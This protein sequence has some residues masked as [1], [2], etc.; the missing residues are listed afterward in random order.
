MIYT[1][2]LCP[3]LDRTVVIPSF[4]PGKVNRVTDS[5]TDPGG[6]G[7]NVSKM[8]RAMGGES[9]ALGIVGGSTGNAIEQSL[10]GM[11]IRTDFVYSRTET[12]VNTKITDPVSGMTTDINSP[13][14]LYKDEA[15][16]VLEKLLTLVKDGD[17][18]VISGKMD[19]KAVDIGA[20]IDALDRAGARVFLDTEKDALRDGAAHGPLLIKPNEFELTHL[21]GKPFTGEEEL[22]DGVNRLMEECGISIVAVSMGEKGAYFFKKDEEALFIE[23]LSVP[24]VC[25][26]GAGDAMTAALTLGYHENMGFEDLCARSVGASA[27]EVTCPGTSVPTKELIDE[28]TARVRIRRL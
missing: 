4:T 18:A 11:G 3:A 23:A 6:K 8:I 14:V 21:T 25:T 16:A 24:C 27:A 20:W 12:R 22:S 26:T 5:R 1:V 28:L 15:D 7:I 2:T 17:C 9:V 19:E 10:G 13:A